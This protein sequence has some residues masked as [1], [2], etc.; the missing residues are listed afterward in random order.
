MLRPAQCE[1]AVT[2]SEPMGR[3][4]W[5]AKVPV[6][7]KTPMDFGIPVTGSL[8]P[9]VCGSRCFCL[10]TA[11]HPVFNG[12]QAEKVERAKRLGGPRHYLR[13]GHVD[14]T[15]SARFGPNFVTILPTGVCVCSI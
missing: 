14:S 4:R 15:E 11:L 13:N 2:I 6:G 9:R 5:G 1:K 12:L 8:D 7:S 3:S 10:L